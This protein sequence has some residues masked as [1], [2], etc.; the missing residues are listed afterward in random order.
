MAPQPGFSASPWPRTNPRHKTGIGGI[1]I[2]AT[3]AVEGMIRGCLV[4]G[5]TGRGI[6]QEG[7]NQHVQDNKVDPGPA[8]DWER[9]L[10]GA[11]ASA[12]VPAP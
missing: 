2:D 5:C 3:T 12:G 6:R 9:V 11:R 8:F 10:A 1:G 7:E 4:R